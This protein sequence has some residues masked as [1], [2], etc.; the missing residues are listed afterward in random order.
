MKSFRC[1]RCESRLEQEDLSAGGFCP[2]CL[3]KRPNLIQLPT[4][5]KPMNHTTA[6]FEM[7][8]LI[9]SI[10]D[11]KITRWHREQLEVNARAKA[12]KYLDGLGE[13]G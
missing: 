7:A 8:D 3:P 12:K 9:V 4:P 11:P 6:A 1:T 13:T 5:E 10:T 2:F